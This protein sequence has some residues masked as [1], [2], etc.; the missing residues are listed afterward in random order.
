MVSINGLQNSGHNRPADKNFDLNV[1]L[2]R[3]ILWLIF[4]GVLRT[5]HTDH[6]I[7]LDLWLGPVP[8]G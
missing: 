7:S 5:F 3:D 8:V 4:T 1:L 6:E 2:K